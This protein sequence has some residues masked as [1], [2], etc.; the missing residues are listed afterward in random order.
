[1]YKEFETRTS[2]NYLKEVIK[3]LNEPICI[4]G[5]WA[6]FFHVNEKFEKAQGRPYLGSRDIDLG[7]NISG[8][9]KQSA[10]SQAISILTKNL[11]FKPLSFRLVKEIHTETE[12]EIKNGEI[13]QAHF[14]FPM[15]VDLIVDSIPRDF[16]EIF[17]FSPIDEPL[18]KTVFEKKEFVIIK[19]FGNKLLLPKIGVLLAMKASSIPNRD[20]EHKKIKDICDMFAL[21]WYSDIK[22]AN[23]N[24]T[25]Y[26]S[27][28]NLKKCLKSITQDGLEKSA[29]QIGHDKEELKRI[30]NLICKK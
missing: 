26:V 15:Y 7:F 9:L 23:V 12:E 5:G 29:A 3:N 20:R 10:L 14:V 19:K 30:I 4:L 13:V 18:L 27:K 22:L 21:A 25:K 6:V 28:N 24:L 8:D 16:R 17:G 11:N 1:M 2:Y